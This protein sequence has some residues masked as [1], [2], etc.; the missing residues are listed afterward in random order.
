[1]PDLSQRSTEQVGL[2]HR[3][4]QLGDG[5]IRSPED[6][7][8]DRRWHLPQLDAL[9]GIA[10]L[11]V[12]MVHSIYWSPEHVL[13]TRWF[14]AFVAFSGQRGVQLFFLVSAFTL[15][16]SDANRKGQRHPTLN[17]FI[18]RFFR[19]TP[20]FYLAIL[21]HWLLHLYSFGTSRQVWVSVLYLAGFVPPTINRIAIGSWS[22]STEAAFYMTLP[23]L[24]R[25]IKTASKAI[26]CTVVAAVAIW[27]ANPYLVQWTGYPD[28]WYLMSLSGNC[29][30]FLMGIAAYFIWRATI[31][32]TQQ[33]QT[34][35]KRMLS[36]ALLVLFCIF[37]L[38]SIPWSIVNTVQQSAF[39]AIFF[40][41]LIMHPWPILVNRFTIGL[42]KISYSVYLLHIYIG[43]YVERGIEAMARH[44][45]WANIPTVQLTAAFLGKLGFT[46][47][48]AFLTWK[49]IE[50]P[51]IGFGRRLI[52]RLEGKRD[53][54]ATLVPPS[55]SVYSRTEN[56]DAQF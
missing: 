37:Y 52:Q 31:A 15:F 50:M 12:V 6:G 25:W 10:I 20:M 42:G 32:P 38:F 54:G 23:L 45:Q 53:G 36:A 47:P 56:P 21:L 35:D 41:A 7:T 14:V 16:L 40:F 22:V 17:F 43:K 39:L 24:Y 28:Y 1:M 13:R 8:A 11:N 19:I 30:V 27:V 18:R 46:L 51:A 33:Q 4:A 9:R 5:H 2:G 3:N 55:Q 44:Y 26:V 49:W 34:P 29:P 48:I